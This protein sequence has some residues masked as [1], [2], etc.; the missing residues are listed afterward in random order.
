MDLATPQVLDNVIYFC[1]IYSL[2]YIVY[3]LQMT[4]G[5]FLS[6]FCFYTRL[7]RVLLVHEHFLLTYSSDLLICLL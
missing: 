3:I 4:L 2:V 5:F 1:S 6:A 7:Y